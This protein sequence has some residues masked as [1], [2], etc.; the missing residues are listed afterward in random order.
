MPPFLFLPHNLSIYPTPSF[1]FKYMAS[2]FSNCYC[3]PPLYLYHPCVYTYIF[4]NKPSQ[5]VIILVNV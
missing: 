2:F 1:S 5:S 4:S 3:M